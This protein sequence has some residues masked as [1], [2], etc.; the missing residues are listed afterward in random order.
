MRHSWGDHPDHQEYQ[1]RFDAHGEQL[2]QRLAEIDSRLGVQRTG[3]MAVTPPPPPAVLP[4][5]HPGS[6]GKY[7]VVSVL[8]SGGQAVVYRVINPHLNKE[9]V[10][11]LSR[12]ACPPDQ[13]G[14]NLL[15]KESRLLAELEHPNLARVHDLDFHQD[16]PFL[17]LEYDS[18]PHA[19]TGGPAGDAAAAPGGRPGGPARAGPGPGTQA[20]CRPP[21][22]ETRQHPD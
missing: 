22:P 14:R 6:I 7:V 20:R 12:R 21:R 10:L 1:A 17:V 19:G 16:C 8:G 4:G 15:V 5:E 9:L 3:P 18:R 11:K 2:R 13:A